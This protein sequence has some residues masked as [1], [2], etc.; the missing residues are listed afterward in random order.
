CA[1]LVLHLDE[2]MTGSEKSCSACVSE[3]VYTGLKRRMPI[4]CSVTLPHSLKTASLTE[5]G[6]NERESPP[7][8]WLW[9]VPGREVH[10][11]ELASHWGC[12]QQETDF[13]DL[14]GQG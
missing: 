1:S 5:P 4:S 2:L 8:L 9:R 13:S 10:T 6:G 12:A 3:D 14:K 11:S 7:T